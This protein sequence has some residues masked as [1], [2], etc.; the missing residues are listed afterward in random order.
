VPHA[1]SYNERQ[2]EQRRH[3]RFDHCGCC[4]SSLF[5]FWVL[6]KIGNRLT[7]LLVTLVGLML[8]ILPS[9]ILWTSPP[10]T[11]QPHAFRSLAFLL[12]ASRLGLIVQPV[13]LR[14]PMV[15]LVGDHGLEPHLAQE[16]QVLSLPTLLVVQQFLLPRPLILYSLPFN[17]SVLETISKLLLGLLL[18]LALLVVI[19]SVFNT[20][21]VVLV[22]L[23]MDNLFPL[24]KLVAAMVEYQLIGP[25]SSEF[26][27]HGLELGPSM[28][29]MQPSTTSTKLPLLGAIPSLHQ[30]Q[31]FQ[32]MLPSLAQLTQLLSPP[33]STML[34]LKCFKESWLEFVLQ[35]FLDPVALLTQILSEKIPVFL[36]SLLLPNEVNL[37]LNNFLLR[38]PFFKP[39][40]Q[41]PLEWLQDLNLSLCSLPFSFIS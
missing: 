36:L 17:Y 33:L 24:D 38:L 12:E 25:H 15:W 20:T 29:S 9:R 30:D 7:S 26:G 4:S 21:L 6:A 18:V 41:P 39:S 35:E 27:P 16:A 13:N 40:R 8:E 10:R 1:G 23:L 2:P 22:L 19:L 11:L 5:L 34:A 37:T 32:L 28:P 3:G 31:L 14:F